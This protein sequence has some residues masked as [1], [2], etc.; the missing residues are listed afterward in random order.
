MKIRY[1][2]SGLMIYMVLL[3]PVMLISGCG[4]EE[5][6]VSV[7]GD[8]L[9]DRGVGKVILERGFDYPFE[10]VTGLLNA[11]DIAFGNLECPITIEGTPVLKDRNLIFRAHPSNAAVLKKAGF[12]VLNLANN[13][14]MDYGCDGLSSTLDL[15][16]GQ[17]MLVAGAGADKLEAH[18]PVYIKKSGVTVGFLGFSAFPPEGYFHSDDKPCVAH[19]DFEKLDESIG[20]AKAGCDYLVVSFHW[21]REFSFYAAESQKELA[22]R[23]LDSGADVIV[24]HHPHVLQGIEIYKGKIIFYSLGNFVFDRQIP[25]GTDETVIINLTVRKGELAGVELIPMKIVQC[26]PVIADKV[27]SK[28]ILERLKLYSGESGSCIDIVGGRGYIMP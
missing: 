12:D 1:W 18:S 19:V 23:V 10:K 9:L 13:H 28:Y 14:T 17:G 8:I 7:A 26:Q 22:R 15:L 2:L 11:S 6:V 21:G 5:I 4:K 24:G 20:K 16:G 27:K 25:P 3:V